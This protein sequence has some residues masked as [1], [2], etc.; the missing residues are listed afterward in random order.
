MTKPEKS[1]TEL[2][3]AVFR[4]A[5]S[6]EDAGGH[7]DAADR[8]REFADDGRFCAAVAQQLSKETT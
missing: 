1:P 2:V 6:V 3:E 8:F 4:A 5:A 7:D